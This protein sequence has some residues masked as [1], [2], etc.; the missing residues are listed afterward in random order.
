M[1]QRLQLTFHLPLVRHI[2]VFSNL[3]L[4]ELHA[5]ERSGSICG[6]ERERIFREALAPLLA[7]PSGAASVSAD[8]AS[9]SAAASSQPAYEAS[10]TLRCA[11]ALTM[12]TLAGFFE[13]H[14]G[15]WVRN[16]NHVRGQAMTYQSGH[17][18][19]SMIDADLSL[20]QVRPLYSLAIHRLRL[21]HA[22]SATNQAAGANSFA[23]LGTR[24]VA[25]FSNAI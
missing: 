4:H 7:S 8:A 20:L 15:L 25:H 17:F 21:T 24:A 9:A 23:R 13:V 19:Y 1:L 14:A 11:A 2:S 10:S 18:C 3:V 5:A 6:A 12:H 16:G 22:A